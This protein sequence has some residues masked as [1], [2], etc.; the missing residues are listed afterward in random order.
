MP[1]QRS[2]PQTDREFQRDE[3]PDARAVAIKAMEFLSDSEIHDLNLPL[4]SV[5]RAVGA[6]LKRQ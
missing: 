4:G 5:M 3:V 2:Q 1:A 6:L